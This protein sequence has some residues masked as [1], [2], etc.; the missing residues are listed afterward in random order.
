MLQTRGNKITYLGHATVKITTP[1]GKVILIDPWVT[2]NPK[3][4]DL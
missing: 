4:P 3:C 1:D 2:T